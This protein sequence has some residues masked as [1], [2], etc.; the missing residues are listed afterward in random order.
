MKYIWIYRVYIENI[1]TFIN[2]VT[3]S[4]FTIVSTHIFRYVTKFAEDSIERLTVKRYSHYFHVFVWSHLTWYTNT[5]RI[6]SHSFNLI[7]L[8][9]T[10]TSICFFKSFASVDRFTIHNF[11]CVKRSMNELDRIMSD[12]LSILEIDVIRVEVCD[13]SCG[14]A[15]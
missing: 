3:I 10:R 6:S 7:R 14:Q 8:I 13:E 5:I 11:H 9:N 12:I 1:F 15:V 2:R 4:I